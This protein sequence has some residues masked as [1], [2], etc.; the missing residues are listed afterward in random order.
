MTTPSTDAKNPTQLADA[1]KRAARAGGAELMR[2][3]GRFQTRSKGDR[4]FVT[5]ADVASQEA[6]HQI[7]LSQF[8]GDAFLGEEGPADGEEVS[9]RPGQVCWIVDPLDGTTNYLH[10][11]PSFAVSIAAVC[12]DIPLA[13][14]IYDPA[15][16]ELFWATRGGGAWLGSERVAT[17]DVEILADGMLAISLPADIDPQSPEIS[18]FARVAPACQAV[19]RTGSAA[20]NLAYLACGRL[21]GYW[22]R[23]INAWDVA[24]GVLLVEEAGGVVSNPQGEP[25]DLWRPAC[26]ASCGQRL[27]DELLNLLSRPA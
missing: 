9:V 16:D 27:H 24:A 10:D 14:V 26:V 11:F 20:L 1:A 3:R 17:S 13:G 7:L 18:D 23:R 15:R 5:D 6:I 4:D 2:L 22:A 19:R 25:F 12:D 8:P 21:D